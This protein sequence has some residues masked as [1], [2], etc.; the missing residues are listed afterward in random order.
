[1]SKSAEYRAIA[2]EHAKLAKTCQ[3]E[4][5]R[6]IHLHISESFQRLAADQEFLGRPAD[7]AVGFKGPDRQ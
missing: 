1:M 5:A 2:A 6:E 3:S 7:S 4:E